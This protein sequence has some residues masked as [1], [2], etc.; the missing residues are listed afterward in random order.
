MMGAKKGELVEHLH[1]AFNDARAR[2]KLDDEQRAR[3]DAWSPAP[4]AIDL[5]AAPGNPQADE[6]GDDDARAD[7]G[8]EPDAIADPQD[9]GADDGATAE[10][11][12]P[13]DAAVATA[14]LAAE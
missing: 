4:L 1:A 13:D 5:T 6:G 3:L 7:A 9:A 10:T 14:P 8:A 12:R 2:A 11:D